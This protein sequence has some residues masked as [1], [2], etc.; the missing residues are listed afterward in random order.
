MNFSTVFDKNEYNASFWA[1]LHLH[2]LTP[3]FLYW[4]KLNWYGRWLFSDVRSFDIINR[5]QY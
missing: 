4:T 2:K 3:H 1:K 5:T